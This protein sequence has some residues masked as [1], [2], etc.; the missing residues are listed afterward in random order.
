MIGLYR[1]KTARRFFHKHFNIP[2]DATVLRVE[3]DNIHF[4]EDFKTFK[5][6][7]WQ[8]KIADFPVIQR[9]RAIATLPFAFATKGFAFLLLTDTTATNNKDNQLFNLA[10]T[11]NYGSSDSMWTSCDAGAQFHAL[12]D[13]TLPSGSGTIS[14]ITL[15]LYKAANGGTN[16]GVNV[17]VH[18][19]TR[20]WNEA[21]ATWNVYSTGNNWSTAGGDYSATVVDSLAHTTTNSIWRTWDLGTGATNPISGLTWGSTVR[22]LLLISPESTT[23]QQAENYYTKERASN[24]PYIEITYT[25]GGGSTF[26]PRTSFFM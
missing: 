5:C 9:L 23:P 11:T 6:R 22:L 2:L 13:F 4:T 15:N 18:E 24:K 19:T 1:T 8:V 16:T 10:A 25:T 26:I 20:D 14:A 3:K 17:E 12:I 21:Q 7:A